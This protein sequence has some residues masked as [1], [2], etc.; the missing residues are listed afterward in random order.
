MSA[1]SQYDS[2]GYSEDVIAD[3]LVNVNRDTL[4]ETGQARYDEL[5]SAIYPAACEIKYN[6]GT[7]SL[8]VA[9]YENAIAQLD[10]VVRMNESYYDGG[11]LLN[12]GLAY[13]GSGDNENAI[14]Y[15]K[16]VIELFPDTEN[17]SQARSNLDTIS[18][19][20]ASGEEGTQE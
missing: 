2:G 20:Q 4:G 10:M 17:A 11:A 19:E 12:L 15:L 7:E 9:N 18:Q 3:T 14:T 13:M 1:S 6:A 5:T 16:R 8:N